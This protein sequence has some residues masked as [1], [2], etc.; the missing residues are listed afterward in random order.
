MRPIAVGDVIIVGNILIPVNVKKISLC[1]VYELE[2]EGT[3]PPNLE[4]GTRW[5]ANDQLLVPVDSV[6]T[7]GPQDKH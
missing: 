6:L 2:S 5:E 1:K 3:A 4:L 7:K